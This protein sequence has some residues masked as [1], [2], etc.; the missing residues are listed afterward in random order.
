M[1]ETW[2]DGDVAYE[3]PVLSEENTKRWQTGIDAKLA[4]GELTITPSGD[5]PDT[6]FYDLSGLCPRC[7]HRGINE[8]FE[9]E[10]LIG[11]ATGGKDEA[12]IDVNCACSDKHE[13]RAEDK[14]GCGWGGPLPVNLRPSR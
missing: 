6:T 3:F 11:V 14:T 5:D 1:T 12:T 8:S 10:V 13:P 7:N 9:V 4:S 2:P